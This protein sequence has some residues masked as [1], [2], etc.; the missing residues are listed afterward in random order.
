MKSIVLAAIISTLALFVGAQEAYFVDGEVPDGPKMFVSGDD[1]LRLCDERPA[2]VEAYVAGVADD[3]RWT[4]YYAIRM[5]DA[6]APPMICMPDNVTT[7]QLKDVVCKSVRS[8]T[9]I[10]RRDFGGTVLAARAMEVAFPCSETLM[11]RKDPG[12]YE[13][14]RK[15]IMEGHLAKLR[16]WA[17]AQELQGED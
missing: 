8:E 9:P 13:E 11:F 5:L 6:S 15:T 10:R 2:F 1:L 3:S 14:Y 7:G 17:K 4:E 12:A 16:A